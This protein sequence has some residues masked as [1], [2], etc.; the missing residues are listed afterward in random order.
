VRAIL[1]SVLTLLMM[2]LLAVTGCKQPADVELTPDA[3]DDDIEMYP[4]TITDPDI[5]TSSIDSSAVLPQE[6]VTY[7]GLCTVN[8]VTWDNG[9]AVRSAAYSRVI[10][11]DSIARF[12]G[13]RVGVRGRDLGTLLLNGSP[14]LRIPHLISVRRLLGRDTSIAF[15]VEY[16][17]DLTRSYQANHQYTWGLSLPLLSTLSVSI[18]SPDSLV[19]TAPRG[20]AVVPRDQKAVIK[21][22]GGG[23]GK[24]RI[25]ISRY[26][27]LAKTL[28]TVLELR[29]KA[30]AGRVGI[31]AK[32]LALLPADRWFILTF[33]LSNRKD[34]AIN[35]GSGTMLV[36][37]AS[38]YNTLVELK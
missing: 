33:V 18:D 34:V 32:V 28:V 2:G 30:S 31:P 15:G 8:S 1:R 37:A 24:M 13:R 5:T 38:V 20:G 6:Q 12:L 25:Y 35:G 9:S 3:G 27:S 36:Q 23:S 26:D 10:V 16:V 14:M 22:N 4:V 17:M 19:I 7:D 29:V 21:W 11:S